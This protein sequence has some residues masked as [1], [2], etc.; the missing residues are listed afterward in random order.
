MGKRITFWR[1]ALVGAALQ[2]FYDPTTGQNRRARLRQDAA[3]LMSDFAS[4]MWMKARDR[5]N[6]RRR[7]L[8]LVE[9]PVP[10]LRMGI[11]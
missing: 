5:V 9:R 6:L 8:S 7:E 4:S 2:Y 1:G 11:V 10:D 3:T